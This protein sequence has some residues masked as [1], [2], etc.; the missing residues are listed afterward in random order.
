MESW[1]ITFQGLCSTSKTRSPASATPVVG[2]P[3]EMSLPPRSPECQ[4]SGQLAAGITLCVIPTVNCITKCQKCEK[5][6]GLAT[7]RCPIHGGT[8]VLILFGGWIFHQTSSSHNYRFLRCQAAI[9]GS[10]T[11]GLASSGCKQLEG[12]RIQYHAICAVNVNMYFKYIYILHIY[13][14]TLD[15]YIYVYIYYIYVY[16]YITCI[17][18]YIHITC[19]YIY[20]L[21]LRI[22]YV[23]YACVYIYIYIWCSVGQPPPTNGY[24]WTLSSGSSGPPPPCGLWEWWGGGGYVYMYVCMSVCLPVCLSVCMSVCL[25]VCMYACMHACMYV[26]MYVYLYLY[27]CYMHFSM[28]VYVYVHAYIN[29][30]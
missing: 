8:L 4:N 15:I 3:K 2:T 5:R 29:I 25:Y 30:C 22:R 1:S 16:I 21:C 6:L 26:C 23:V 18:I 9:S 7:W 11:T 17:Y 27:T 13:I 10:S 24:G 12:K 28:I 19:I 20:I 14:Y